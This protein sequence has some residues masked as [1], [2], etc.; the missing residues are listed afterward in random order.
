MEPN[1]NS[2]FQVSVKGLFFNEQGK[3]LMIQEDNG[4]WEIPGGR[5]QKGEQFLETLQ[6]ECQEEMG[7]DCTILDK[8][9]FIVY[10]TIDLEGRPR[11][12]VYFKIKFD[13][14]DFKPSAECVAVNF[15]DKAEIS[16]LE[17]Y[18][19]LKALLGYL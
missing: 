8:E 1:D 2:L 15:Y 14:V 13:S 3:L 11:I 6:R 7:L 12:M 4:L 19:Q 5:I 17:I 10:P 18:P 9:P 16:E